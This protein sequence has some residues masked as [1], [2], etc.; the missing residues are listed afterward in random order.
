MKGLLGL[1]MLGVIYYPTLAQVIASLNI[2][3]WGRQVWGFQ[4]QAP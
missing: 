3:R 1:G 4:G 2:D